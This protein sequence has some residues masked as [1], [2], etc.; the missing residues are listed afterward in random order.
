MT[1]PHALAR[2]LPLHDEVGS[3]EPARRRVQEPPQDRTRHAERQIRDDAVRA[4][5]QRDDACIGSHHD[6]VAGGGETSGE[7]MHELR[8]ELDREDVGRPIRE[9]VGEDSATGAELDHS[10]IATDAGVGDELRG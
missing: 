7:D 1:D 9:G 10:M 5:G 4:R 8:I 6:N 2:D 3:L